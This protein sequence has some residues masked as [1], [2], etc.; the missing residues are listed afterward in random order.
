MSPL[1]PQTLYL[2]LPQRFIEDKDD[3]YKSGIKESS[4]IRNLITTVQRIFVVSSKGINLYLLGEKDAYCIEIFD[5]KTLIGKLYYF[6]KEF[7][8]D[9][10]DGG[11]PYTPMFVW[12]SKRCI[13]KNIPVSLERL[14]VETLF[15]P[16]LGNI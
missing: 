10:Y 9:F 3:F 8:L 13:Y 15:L 2:Q 16:L 4:K 12:K 1:I 11:D 14:K 7:R 5:R 6:P